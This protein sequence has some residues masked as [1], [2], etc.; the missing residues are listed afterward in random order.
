MTV[1]TLQEKGRKLLFPSSNKKRDGRLWLKLKVKT[2][3]QNSEISDSMR[4]PRYRRLDLSCLLLHAT[5]RSHLRPSAPS[6]C[7]GSLWTALFGLDV[8]IADLV[9]LSESHSF[10]LRREGHGG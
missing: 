2:P 9:F 6:Q 5:T 4:V 1:V 3:N 8:R 10:N 7:S